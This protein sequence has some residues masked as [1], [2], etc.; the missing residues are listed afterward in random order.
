MLVAALFP[1]RTCQLP[2]RW[3]FLALIAGLLVHLRRNT[4]SA[5]ALMICCC[6]DDLLLIRAGHSY[7]PLLW[8]ACPSFSVYLQQLQGPPELLHCCRA[9]EGWLRVG[10]AYTRLQA[11]QGATLALY[12]QILVLLINYGLEQTCF[13]ILL[14]AGV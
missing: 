14:D 8:R 2:G 1:A 12:W 4:S 7:S 13:A 5:I 9:S 10:N 3:L 6:A 11:P